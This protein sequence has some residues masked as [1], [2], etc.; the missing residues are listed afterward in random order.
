MEGCAVS[1]YFRAIVTD[2]DER[3]RWGTPLI[4]E[5]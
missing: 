4:S 3:L 2:L 5:S 1:V